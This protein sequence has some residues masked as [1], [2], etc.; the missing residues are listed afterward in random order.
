MHQRSK[1]CICLSDNC[2]FFIGP[3]CNDKKPPKIVISSSNLMAIVFI[4]DSSLSYRGFKATYRSLD[5][6]GRYCLVKVA[7][8]LTVILVGLCSSVIR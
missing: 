1:H 2:L 3:Y 5:K 8:L 6:K 7:Q 4:S